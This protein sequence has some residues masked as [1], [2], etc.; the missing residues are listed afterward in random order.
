MN[1]PSRW[2]LTV[3][4]DFFFLQPSSVGNLSPYRILVKS[5]RLVQLDLRENWKRNGVNFLASHSTHSPNW[6]TTT[7]HNEIYLLAHYL[8]VVSTLRRECGQLRWVCLYIVFSP[9]LIITGWVKPFAAKRFQKWQPRF[10]W[11]SRFVKTTKYDRPPDTLTNI[12][13]QQVVIRLFTHLFL[14]V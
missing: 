3:V 14:L 6:E 4:D 8:I 5:S 10:T 12:Q 13:Q 7:N 1:V 2:D 11:V 9:I